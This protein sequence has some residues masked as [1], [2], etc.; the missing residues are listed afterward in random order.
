MRFTFRPHQRIRHTKEF[1]EVRARG[2]RLDCA[3]CVV[4]ILKRDAMRGSS[5]LGVVAS[6]KVGCAV[7]R[8]RVKRR[9]RE[10]FRLHQHGIPASWDMVI[11]ARPTLPATSTEI[12]TEKLSTAVTRARNTLGDVSVA[13]VSEASQH[14]VRSTFVDALVAVYDGVRAFLT[15]LGVPEQSCRFE[16]SCSRYAAM[17]CKELGWWR[18]GAEAL[19]RLS[20]CHPFN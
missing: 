17:A 19:K 5:R 4:F 7:V 2:V 13:L 8:N 3:S 16:P 15:C 1:V 14:P 12:L 9:L 20:R 6:R 18:G 11:V 10:W